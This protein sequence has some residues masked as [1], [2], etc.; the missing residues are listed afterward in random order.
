MSGTFDFFNYSFSGLISIFAALVG[1]AYP[2]IHQAIQRVDE[3][4]ESTLLAGYVQRQRPIKIFNASLLTA[5][6]F[7]FTVPFLLRW[8]RDNE[9]VCIVVSL[10]HSLVILVLLLSVVSLY[11]FLQMKIRPTHMLEFIKNHPDGG[12]PEGSLLYVAEIAKFASRR[13]DPDLFMDSTSHI[14]HVITQLRKNNQTFESFSNDVRATLLKLS[15]YFAEKSS[16]L[17]SH[18][19][20]LSSI[21]FDIEGCYPFSDE[22]F[23][24]IWRTL[25]L[26]LQSGNESFVSGYWSFADQYYRS[27]LR[28]YYT[29]HYKDADI[30]QFHDRYLEM[31]TM[32][33]AL[34][35]FN[36]R[37]PLLKTIMYFSN[38]EPPYYHLVPSSFSKIHESMISLYQQS[39]YPWN[40]AHSYLMIGM[41]SD[42]N[43]DRD[44]LTVAYRYH[45]ILTIRLFT[46]N[47]Y[48]V[49]SKSKEIPE[50]TL[51]K[52]ED[53]EKDIQV[54]NRLL[55]YIKEYYTTD[56]LET[57]LPMV[58]KQ[59]DVV[60]LVEQYIA[61]CNAKI[62]EIKETHE[63]DY[64]KV[65]YIKENLIKNASRPLYMPASA[66]VVL[67]D[68]KEVV[69]SP[70]IRWKFPIDT[71][72]VETGTYTN[73]SNLPDVIIERL[74]S[75]AWN[76]Y[77]SIFIRT[78]SISD[79]TIRFKDVKH[80]LDQLGVN[81]T[82]AVISL[83]VYFGTFDHL[84][85]QE[86]DPFDENGDK[87]YYHKAR[88]Y[89]VPSSAQC[90]IV[91]KKDDVPYY[92]IEQ[93]TEPQLK[94]VGTGLGLY[95]NIDSFDKITDS[96][97]FLDTMRS[98]SL[99]YLESLKYIRLNIQH[100]SEKP[101]DL[102]KI[103]KSIWS[104]NPHE[105][106]EKLKNMNNDD[107]MKSVLDCFP[108]HSDGTIKVGNIILHQHLVAQLN[109][110]PMQA[111]EL[112]NKLCDLGYLVYED[113]SENKVA[114]YHLTEKGFVFYETQQ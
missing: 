76:A 28:G 94:E 78:Q 4:Y 68:R 33:G 69:L 1:M 61:K 104:Y 21:F 109:I 30:R 74:N 66:D 41:T 47:D 50:V 40:L 2:L 105:T 31:H 17:M 91:M 84:Y 99:H 32:L 55:A 110:G 34:L 12:R 71:E 16:G 85:G 86:G 102:N 90:L 6:A 18:S 107:L 57:C 77:N 62:K 20:L 95:S 93:N 89:N 106:I 59:E 7:S 64:T 113:A 5:I 11:N 97:I 9:V 25:D 114:G 100:Y 103:D 72:I 27:V 26:V 60:G 42:V 88:I 45:A 101:L 48:F 38:E 46:I 83:G 43:C 75:F 24:Y 80:A 19:T 37:F 51:T 56:L 14:T 65:E 58:P 29:Q 35:V 8:F 82:F 92:T 67:T 39:Y 10:I 23:C 70:V 111:K 15:Q 63:I 49:F 13:N 3:M 44:I 52:I 96:Q 22:E 112:L 36:N 79:Y 108:G 81:E 54:T 73:A 87:M 98:I 53:I